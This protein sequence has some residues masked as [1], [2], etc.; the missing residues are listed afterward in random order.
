MRIVY[1]SCSYSFQQ[2][3]NDLK[4]SAGQQVIFVQLLRRGFLRNHIN[5]DRSLPR[6]YMHSHYLVK[7]DLPEIY[8]LLNTKYLIVNEISQEKIVFLSEIMMVTYFHKKRE[9]KLKFIP[10]I[11][12][13]RS[14]KKVARS[15]SLFKLN[16]QFFVQILSEFEFLIPKKIITNQTELY[17]FRMFYKYYYIT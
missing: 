5:Y 16:I 7:R 15:I 1:V 9:Y 2:K 14:D 3:V 13:Y 6:V 12:K 10:S 11:Q 17:S 4:H 8:L